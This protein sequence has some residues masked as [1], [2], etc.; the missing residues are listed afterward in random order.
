VVF[1][2]SDLLLQANLGLFTDTH[3]LLIYVVLLPLMEAI[4]ASFKFAQKQDVFINN[5]VVVI[6]VC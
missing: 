5:F 6:K 2:W 3:L 1:C 4:G